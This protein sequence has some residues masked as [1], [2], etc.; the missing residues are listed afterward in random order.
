MPDI[1]L[2]LSLQFDSDDASN[3]K[4]SASRLAVLDLM[5]GFSRRRDG[6]ETSRY[7]LT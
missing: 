6:E 2:R 5:A 4:T 1:I 3:D 7:F